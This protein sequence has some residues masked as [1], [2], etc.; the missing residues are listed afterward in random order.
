LPATKRLGL[1]AFQSEAYHI[2]K[3]CNNPVFS[4]GGIWRGTHPG[5]AKA[6][7][8]ITQW[9]HHP[10]S[11]H[12]NTFQAIQLKHENISG[13]PSAQRMGC[14]W[15]MLGLS[16]IQVSALWFFWILPRVSNALRMDFFHFEESAPVTPVSGQ[17]PKP[18]SQPRR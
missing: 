15:V 16:L 5:A 3:A 14:G 17:K 9:Q 10:A 2:L 7:S 4:L 12:P 8:I 1:E 6:G 11:H 18:L 13:A